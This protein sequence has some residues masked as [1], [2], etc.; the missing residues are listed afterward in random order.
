MKKLEI[1]KA[2]DDRIIHY[3]IFRDLIYEEGVKVTSN[4]R[5]FVTQPRDICIE[6]TKKCNLRCEN[7]FIEN[8]DEE[9]SYNDI[10]NTIDKIKDKIIRICLSGGEP[11]LYSQIDNTLAFISSMNDLGKVIST[12]GTCIND[13]HI[14]IMKGNYWTVA[15]SIHGRK[16]THNQYTKSSSYD[17]VIKIIEKLGKNGINTHIYSVMHDRMS[18]EDY[19]FIKRIK[20]KYEIAVLRMIKVRMHG[21][22][23]I[24]NNNELFTAVKRDLSDGII[25][26]TE[27]TNTLLLSVNG[28]MSYTN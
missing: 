13:D 4:N 17:T 1:V 27:K 7:C 28:E 26:K 19:E 14:N 3:D 18:L 15:V 10:Y 2:I 16:E 23:K 22:Y 20:D 9:I 24:D 21:R 11:F 5:S 8:G 6:L 12:N 25:L